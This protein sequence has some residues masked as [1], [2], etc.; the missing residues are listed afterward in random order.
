LPLAAAGVI[1]LAGPAIAQGVDQ[2][3]GSEPGVVDQ[4]DPDD[5]MGHQM[6]MDQ[7]HEQM[8]S[9]VPGMAQMHEQMLNEMPGMADMHEQMTGD[10]ETGPPG[11]GR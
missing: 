10:D 8:T 5:P 4:V 2:P 3:A 9:Q 7:M 6:D 1:A 11:M